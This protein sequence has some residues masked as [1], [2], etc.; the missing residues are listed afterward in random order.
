M[1]KLITA[2]LLLLITV[3][4]H[5]S[6]FAATMSCKFKQSSVNGVHTIDI[7]DENLIINNELEIP[8]EKTRVKCGNFGRQTRLDGSA[9]G[10]QVVLRSCTTDANLEGYL[11]DEVHSVVGEVLCFSDAE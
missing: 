11:I 6:A 9:L 3:I 7:N 8:L 4:S 2:S 5:N 10:F 1:K